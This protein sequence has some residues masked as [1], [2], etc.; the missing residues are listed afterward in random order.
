MTF[1]N[2][3]ISFQKVVVYTIILI[4]LSLSIAITEGFSGK[5]V[6]FLIFILIASIFFLEVEKIQNYRN[7]IRIL[8]ENSFFFKTQELFIK[9]MVVIDFY[10]QFIKLFVLFLSILDVSLIFLEII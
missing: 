8:T 3:E 2:I 10:L 9:R 7:F 5:V 4:I 1:Y 6:I